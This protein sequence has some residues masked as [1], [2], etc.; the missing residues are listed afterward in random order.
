MFRAMSLTCRLAA[1]LAFSTLSAAPAFASFHLN[2]VNEVMLSSG[3]DGTAQF[4]ELFDAA[5][6]PYPSGSGP[7]SLSIYDAGGTKIG[8]SIALASA[9]LAAVA[10]TR[11]FLVSTASADSKLSVTGDVVLGVTLPA[12]G[13]ACFDANAAHVHCLAWGTITTPVT[14]SGG[15]QA[16]ASPADGSSLQRQA[17][18]TYAVLAPTPKAANA[19]AAPADMAMNSDLGASSGDLAVVVTHDLAMSGRDLAIED[20]PKSSGGCS[21]GGRV[22][23]TSSALLVA[24]ALLGLTLRRRL[25]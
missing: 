21:Y 11:P 18:G 14:G 6:E 13:Q 1:I 19:T 23:P 12:N 9:S 25:A 8:S 10:G 5:A 17:G 7:Y 3:G 24:L 16:G 4:V 15:N 22:P 2:K 20:Q